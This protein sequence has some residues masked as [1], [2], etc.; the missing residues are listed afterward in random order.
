MLPQLTSE[1]GLGGGVKPWASSDGFV[2]S[3]LH[4]RLYHFRAPFADAHTVRNPPLSLSLYVIVPSGRDRVVPCGLF[5]LSAESF[6]IPDSVC[7]F[8]W[9][10]V[11]S[12]VARR[13]IVLLTWRVA[14]AT[15]SVESGYG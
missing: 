6:G 2:G 3:V 10:C 12:G 9:F 13:R 11:V 4:V 7:A 8:P 15:T 14:P 5:F 1:A